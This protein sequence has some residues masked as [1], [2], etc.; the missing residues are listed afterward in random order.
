M[1]WRC[2]QETE[3]YFFSPPQSVQSLD[4]WSLARLEFALSSHVC[5]SVSFAVAEV[6]ALSQLLLVSHPWN[7]MS[8]TPRLGL[9]ATPA[10]FLYTI[11]FNNKDSLAFAIILND[12]QY[13]LH[14]CINENFSQINDH[15]LESIYL[16][17]LFL[18]LFFFTLSLSLSHLLDSEVTRYSIACHPPV[19]VTEVI[20]SCFSNQQHHTLGKS[21]REGKR[22]SEWNGQHLIY[23]WHIWTRFS[24]TLS[25]KSYRS[26]GISH[27][28]NPLEFRSMK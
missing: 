10:D 1:C 9:A 22:K 8:W 19:F 13:I 18:F 26:E 23:S 24:G 11:A 7:L 17:L 27:L 20:Y 21:E 3:L 16:S 15:C 2:V 6:T 14:Y 5:V 12:S 4:Y 28:N 25:N